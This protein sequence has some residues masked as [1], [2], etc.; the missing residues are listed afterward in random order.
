MN[1]DLHTPEEWDLIARGRAGDPDAARGILHRYREAVFDFA[2]RTLRDLPG[3]LHATEEALGE[4]LRDFTGLPADAAFRPWLFGIAYRAALRH[5][6]PARAP[7]TTPPLALAAGGV[8]AGDAAIAWAGF[9]ELEPRQYALLDLQLRRGLATAEIAQIVGLSTENVRAMVARLRERVESGI[10]ARLLAERGRDRCP[11]LD[12]LL[13]ELGPAAAGRAGRVAV[14]RHA[15]TCPICGESRR[16]LI[17]PA[18]IFAGLAAVAAPV[19]LGQA[20]AAGTGGAAADAANLSGAADAAREGANLAG[21]EVAGQAHVASGADARVQPAGEPANAGAPSSG[22]ADAAQGPGESG[23]ADAAQSPGESAALS[24]DGGWPAEE[25]TQSLLDSAAEAGPGAGDPGPTVDPFAYG[26]DAPATL[27]MDMR[28]PAGNGAGG[29]YY[30]PPPAPMAAAGGGSGLLGT[31]AIVI[32]GATLL[33]GFVAAAIGL[34]LLSNGAAG[35]QAAPPPAVT[36]V[37][38]ASPTSAPAVLPPVPPTASP[39]V[40]GVVELPTAT[41]TAVGSAPPESATAPLLAATETP[42]AVPPTR[43]PT[44]VPAP[45]PATAPPVPPTP[46]PPT[47]APATN[48]PV[49]PSPVPPTP[50]P[51]TSTPVPPPP[52]PPTNTPAPATNTPTRTPTPTNTPVVAPKLAVSTQALAFGSNATQQSFQIQ[53]AGG[54]TLQWSVDPQASWI[55][56]SPAGGQNNGTVTVTI[57]R[58][59]LGPG[60]NSGALSISSNGGAARIVVTANGG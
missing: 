36:A 6:G 34:Y 32:G 45:P 1:A 12:R 39:T 41:P 2:M 58:R 28:P 7:G 3:A 24:G 18:A 9:A 49:P 31:F 53:N 46:V 27:S 26:P 47:P 8:A 42:T 15:E 14:E 29:G 48:T 25:A 51:P 13:V 17:A 19:G 37:A 57:N 43:T 56:V 59:L 60:Q 4:A 55:S 21:Q 38:F 16:G 22:A 23:A 50:A 52:P 35:G 11:E 30:A 5:L 33:L 44:R 54:G 20:L 40:G 10:T